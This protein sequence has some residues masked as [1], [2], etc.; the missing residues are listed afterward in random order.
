MNRIFFKTLIFISV[1]L[2]MSQGFSQ[3]ISIKELMEQPSNAILVENFYQIKLDDYNNFTSNSSVGF[4]QNDKCYIQ[5][6]QSETGLNGQ[7]VLQ[8]DFAGKSQYI[9]IS[10][11]FMD[12]YKKILKPKILLLNDLESCMSG[13]SSN[14]SLANCMVQ[15]IISY[16]S[17]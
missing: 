14:W 3:K 12:K 2:K 6:L 17:D 16:L 15:K 11:V 9:G 13:I 10:K 8:F 1:F 7:I 5:N 4:I